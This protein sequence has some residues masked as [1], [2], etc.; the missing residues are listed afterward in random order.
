ME[1]RSFSNLHRLT[2]DGRNLTNITGVIAVE[3][4]DDQEIV[5]ETEMGVLSISGEELRIKHLDLENGGK[6]IIEGEIFAA[7]YLAHRKSSKKG[8]GFL[9]RI[10]R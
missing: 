4:F 8:K 5:L 2:I 7:N 3:S 6:V 1:D 10:L 9:E